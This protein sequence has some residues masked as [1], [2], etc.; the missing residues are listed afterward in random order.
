MPAR[1]VQPSRRTETVVGSQATGSHIP[2]IMAALKDLFRLRG[3][4]SK[5]V[6]AALGVTERTLARW[7]AGS[8]VALQ[9]LEDLCRI[10]GVTVL[11]LLDIVHEGRGPLVTSLSVLQEQELADTPYCWFLLAHLLHGIP[12]SEAQQQFELPEPE[13]V[14]ALVKLE[15]MGLVTLLPG[16]RVRLRV[17]RNL[18]WR[19]NGPIARMRENFFRALLDETDFVDGKYVAE[20]NVTRLSEASLAIVEDKMRTLLQEILQ[21]AQADRR[22]SDDAACD[23]YVLLIAAHKLE[24][25]PHEF[26]RLSR[27]PRPANAASGK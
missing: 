15:S 9:T 2:T 12:V 5:D 20:T 11:D 19:K 25:T 6:A 18:T 13:V 21:M 14:L 3:M 23:W 10:A 8:G 24:K 16:N 17:S 7:M 1:S 22:L 4:P 27:P 26:L